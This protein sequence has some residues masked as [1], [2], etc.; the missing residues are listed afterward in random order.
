MPEKHIDTIGVDR[1]SEAMKRKLAKKRAEGRH[2]WDNPDVCSER[3]LVQLFFDELLTDDSRGPDPV[4][5]ANFL[6]MI[7][8]R[9]ARA[10]LKA[11]SSQLLDEID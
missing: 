2:G 4:D 9:N 8:G 7:W 10:E 1:F 6:M 11:Q 5:L 3:Y